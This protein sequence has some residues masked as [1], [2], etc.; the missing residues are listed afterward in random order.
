MGARV[1]VGNT[2]LYPQPQYYCSSSRKCPYKSDSDPALLQDTRHL[3]VGPQPLPNSNLTTLIPII[4]TMGPN[5]STFVLLIGTLASLS[6]SRKCTNGL[7]YCGAT[8]EGVG[9]YDGRA[10]RQAEHAACHGANGETYRELPGRD[11]GREPA[12]RGAHGPP[13]SL[14]HSVFVW[15]GR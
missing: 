14:S 12:S 6:E 7:S 10:P 2:S 3:N 4:S 5:F 15:G 9:T 8:L 13:V 11:A 1:G